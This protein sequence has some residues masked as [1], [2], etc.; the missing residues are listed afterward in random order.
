ML[1]TIVFLG[2][3]Y[4]IVPVPTNVMKITEVYQ[5]ADGRVS[6]H[7]EIADEYQLNR[8]QFNMD[9]DGNFYITP[10]RPFIKTKDVLKASF[11]KNMYYTFG[12]FSKTVYRN[13]FGDDAEI[14]AFYYG[15]PKNNILVWKKEMNL[16]K[17][18]EKVEEFFSNESNYWTY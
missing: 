14:K 3:T 9:E 5:L 10:K 17:A 8:I 18:N 6:Y 7:Y 2:F 11:F 1:F 16:P 4:P 15:T 13:K 12:D